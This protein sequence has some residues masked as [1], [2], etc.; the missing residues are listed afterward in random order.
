VDLQVGG[1]LGVA[2]QVG[3]EAEGGGRDHHRHDGE[4][5]EAVGE[6]HGIA[7]AGDDEHTHKDEEQPQIQH[8]V[9]EERQRQHLADLRRP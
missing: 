1:E 6:V 5:V 4:A 7:G 2:Y 8:D 3:D 9:L